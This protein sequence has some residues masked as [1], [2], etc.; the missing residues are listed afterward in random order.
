[1][2]EGTKS[3]TAIALMVMSLVG[4]VIAVNLLPT[5][6][7]AVIPTLAGNFTDNNAGL[8]R[9]VMQFIPVGFGAGTLAIG[10]GIAV[11][12]GVVGQKS[13]TMRPVLLIF[14]VIIVVIGVN[15]VGT[16]GNAQQA[17]IRSTQLSY[18][19]AA[20]GSTPPG[21]VQAA[22]AQAIYV[23]S[24]KIG[25]CTTVASVCGSSSP[26]FDPAIQPFRTDA[27]S[28]TGPAVQTTAQG[29]AGQ[30]A[31]TRTVVGFTQIGFMVSVLAGAFS[32][33]SLGGG[34]V[35][36]NITGAVGRGGRRLVRPIA[37]RM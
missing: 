15:L 4:L 20:N 1:M 2:G 35:G 37:Q 18:G 9:T 19:A 32:L 11:T 6:V 34:E 27:A 28:P 16:V 36:R 23:G 31:L 10:F 29:V 26:S 8:T 14:S 17:A 33:A 22:A 13:A 12:T 5:V 25:D 21:T 3:G 30:L 24:T 7:G